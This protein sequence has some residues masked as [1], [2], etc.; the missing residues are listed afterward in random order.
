VIRDVLTRA[1]RTQTLLHALAARVDEEHG[2][3]LWLDGVRA[4]V[5]RALRHL[6]ACAAACQQ[7]MSAHP[8]LSSVPSCCCAALFC[9]LLQ[10]SFFTCEDCSKHFMART[11]QPDVS[12]LRAG[13]GARG[14]A[15]ALWAWRV[16]N[17]VNARL[18]GE[19]AAGGGG[20]AAFPKRPWPQPGSCPS[21]ACTRAD[22]CARTW[23]GAPGGALW[24]E[25]AVEGFLDRYYGPHPSDPPADAWDPF[26]LV[27]G[28]G[29]EGAGGAAAGGARGAGKEAADGRQRHG[30]AQAHHGG[31]EGKHGDKGDGKRLRGRALDA[32]DVTAESLRLH[33]APG[34]LR[35]LTFIALCAAAP[36]CIYAGCVALASRQRRGGAGGA[37]K[38]GRL[39]LSRATAR[40]VRLC[41]SCAACHL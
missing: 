3:A 1:S 29:R 13:G 32:H 16:H 33:G 6:R 38:P 37:G 7:R 14:P 2:G 5:V 22:G 20:D 10:G 24:D 11:A 36:V 19:E 39:L 23:P 21:C 41:A 18:A 40:M 35:P 17:E 30:H 28:D 12:S 27:D 31:R 4:F 34:G 25:A 15:A 9:V 26:G 8:A